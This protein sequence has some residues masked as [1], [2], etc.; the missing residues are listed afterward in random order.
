MPTYPK[1]TGRLL[2]RTTDGRA[3]SFAVDSPQKIRDDW[4]G[5]ERIMR[6]YGPC[7]CCGIR[8]YAFD[9]G[10]NDPRGVLGDHS[11]DPLELADHLSPE[12]A[13]EVERIG[14]ISLPACFG[15]TN[16]YG[17]Y[18]AL[19]ARATRRARSKGADI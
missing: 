14:G 4:R 16:D 2:D 17:A 3:L 10:E 9:D 6:Y 8:T 18:Q 12:E 15:C 19:I 5:T 1:S 7:S 13:A 11:A